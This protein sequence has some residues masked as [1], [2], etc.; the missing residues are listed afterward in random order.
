MVWYIYIYTSEFIA[1]VSFHDIMYHHQY[2]HAHV[3]KHVYPAY[4]DIINFIHGYSLH[5]DPSR[6]DTHMYLTLESNM[7]MVLTMAMCMA[8]IMSV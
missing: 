3:W 7:Q 6:Q 8:L 2:T 5:E 1:S 4:S